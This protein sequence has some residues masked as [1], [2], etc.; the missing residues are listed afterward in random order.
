MQATWQDEAAAQ[1]VYLYL[2]ATG[3]IYAGHV[4]APARGCQQQKW[5]QNREGVVGQDNL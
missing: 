1:C 3:A 4:Y 2:C 5:Q